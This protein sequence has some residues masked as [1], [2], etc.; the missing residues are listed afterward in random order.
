[1]IR[2]LQQLGDYVLQPAINISLV[3]NDHIHV[4]EPQSPLSIKHRNNLQM[5]SI[6]KFNIF[7][8][9]KNKFNTFF[10]WQFLII[11]VFRYS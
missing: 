6:P 5:L 4:N 3:P 7:V 10:A 1:M 11:T 9:L 8:T 2:Y